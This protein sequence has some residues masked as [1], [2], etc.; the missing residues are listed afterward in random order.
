MTFMTDDIDQLT[1][2]VRATVAR[3][4]GLPVS[5]IGSGFRRGHARAWDSMGH[6][7]VIMEIEREFGV[8]LSTQ[9]IEELQSITEI[10]SAVSRMTPTAHDKRPLL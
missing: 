10:A 3:A 7:A 1:T 8:R 5:D 6:L 4:L 9:Q 2:R